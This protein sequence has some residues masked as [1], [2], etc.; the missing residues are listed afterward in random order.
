MR[1]E[2][3]TKKMIL[4]EVS[5]IQYL[6]GLKYEIRYHHDRE[7][8]DYT[9]SVAEHVYGMHILATYFLPLE[10]PNK[11]W[12]WQKIYE[13][14]T[15]HDIDEVE[16]GD[17]IGYLKTPKVRSKEAKAMKVV[18]SKSPDHLR[19]YMTPILEEYEALSSSEAKFV[20]AIDR[21]EPLFHLYNERGRKTMAK[22]RTTI[23]Q[24]E[25][26]KQPYVQDFPFIRIFSNTV[27]FVMKEEGY[28]FEE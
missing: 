5:K 28:F 13:M 6:Y 27:T 22:N 21:V 15:W 1:L 25:S 4:S 14:I 16:T 8:K 26:L 18:L 9:E 20:K 24:S 23:E 12:D 7:G 10:D 19:A 11:E 2:D 17:M 3:L